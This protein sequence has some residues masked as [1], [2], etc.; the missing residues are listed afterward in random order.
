MQIGE[1]LE[2]VTDF[3]FLGSRI[4]VDG[5]CNHE[6]RTRLLFGRK[7]MTNLD[8]VEKQ[9][10]YSANEDPYSQ[11]YGLPSG[12]VQ[13]WELDRKEAECQKIDAF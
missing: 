4:M 13:L 9:R 1:K 3:F 12:H 2:V 6:I 7:M 5:D 10:H 11:G 8:S